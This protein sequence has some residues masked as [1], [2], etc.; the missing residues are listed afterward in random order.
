MIKNIVFD[1]GNVLA[2]YSP[3][4][5]IEKLG[6]N[7]ERV[8]YVNT[9]I[10]KEKNWTKYL[11]GLISL[12]ELLTYYNKLNKEYKLEIEMLL[13]KENQKYIIYEIEKNTKLL[14]K[15]SKKCNIYIL[16]NITK[17]TYEYIMDKFSF[18]ENIKGGVYS[19]EEHILKPDKKIFEILINKYNIN[20]NES[21]YIDDKEKNIDTANKLGFTGIQCKLNDNLEDLL[22]EEGINIEY[23]G[24][25]C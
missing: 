13:K 6:T 20:P 16:S 23:T 5:E 21:I 19:F 18:K 10:I 9:L 2:G 25:N 1:I 17:E 4:M 8:E 15:L 3:K 22:N 24:Y 12:D 11:N 7:I 14:K